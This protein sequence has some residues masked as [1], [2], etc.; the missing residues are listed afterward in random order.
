MS[1]NKVRTRSWIRIQMITMN[2]V[3]VVL[4]Y[5]ITTTPV[6]TTTVTVRKTLQ[7]HP[8]NIT[9]FNSTN[10]TT[11][12]STKAPTTASTKTTPTTTVTKTQQQQLGQHQV[13]HVETNVSFYSS[14]SIF[15][16][17]NKIEHPPWLITSQKLYFYILFILFLLFLD[18]ASSLLKPFFTTPTHLKNLLKYV[19]LP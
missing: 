4:I 8:K 10:N 5:Y 13:W 16:D 2:L 9:T 7:Q 6:S 19:T 1:K 3:V 12:T 18:A 15:V 14:E 17:R 11:T